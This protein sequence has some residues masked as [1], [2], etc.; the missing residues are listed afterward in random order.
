M[1]SSSL[2][3]SGLASDTAPRTPFALSDLDQAVLLTVL[4]A[5]LFDYPLTADDLYQRLIHVAADRSSFAQAL[6][7]LTGPYL[8]ATGDYFTWVGREHLVAVRQ[9][10]QRIARRLWVLARRYA[11]WLARVPFVRMVA[12]SG[13]LAVYNAEE[14]S[15][16]DLFCI[17]APNRLWLTRAC[18]VPL[19][20]LTR[21][22]PGRFPFYLCPNYLLAQNNLDVEGHNLFTAHEVT[23]AVPLW[24]ETVYR[25]FVHDNT[26]VHTF[27]PHACFEAQEYELRAPRHPWYTRCAERLLRG[28]LGDT[29]D[30]LVY[31]GFTTFYR[32][33]A[34]RAG[35]SWPRLATAYQRTR[36]TVPEGGYARVV[37]RR[38]AD[39]VTRRLGLHLSPDDLALFFPFVKQTTPSNF[40]DWEELFAKDYGET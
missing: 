8:T 26:W 33:R 34:E 10:R 27:L 40:Y 2:S 39:R 15:D 18:I 20:K 32:K 12:V 7:A 14:K 22:L 3:P 35:W 36:Y 37:Q 21:L 5:D 16:I 24:G 9:R 17:T 6:A 1:P 30:R 25:H 4:Y 23:Q 28:R 13:S 11:R 19:S 31:R 38:F 29:L